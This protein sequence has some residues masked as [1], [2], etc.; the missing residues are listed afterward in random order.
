VRPA[1]VLLGQKMT[2]TVTVKNNSAVDA[3]DVDVVK[4]NDRSYHT[5]LLSLKPSHG[6]CGE[7]SCSLGEIAPGH[8]VTITAVTLATKIGLIVNVVRVGSEEKEGDYLNN[9][10]S[11]VARVIG[12]F[13]PQ[14]KDPGCRSLAA[15]PRKLRVGTTTIVVTTA[16]N[17]FGARV[18][19]I[20]VHLQASGISQTA[21]TNQ[22]G[23]A[24]FTVTPNRSGLIRFRGALSP[25]RRS[26]A[27]ALP[28]NV[29]ICRTLLAA[30]STRT[31]R[32]RVTG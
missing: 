23:N 6:S 17:R 30:L 5:K 13:R 10:A 16:R 24:V 12:P 31:T 11:A 3:H 14:P 27:Q 21:R 32:P 15:V 25:A 20:T 29:R 7:T 28:A 2:W 26:T 19:G 1:T 4:V 18:P 22:A 9:T 8:S